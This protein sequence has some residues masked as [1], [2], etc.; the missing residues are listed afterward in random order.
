MKTVLNNI[1]G[2][3]L[4]DTLPLFLK[5]SSFSFFLASIENTGCSLAKVCKV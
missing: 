5:F 2:I 3:K 4:F 1:Y